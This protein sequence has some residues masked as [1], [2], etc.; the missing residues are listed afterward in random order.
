MQPALGSGEICNSCRA[1]SP[2]KHIRL[3]DWLDPP[4]G[5]TRVAYARYMNTI[6][7]CKR[8][9]GL[10]SVIATLALVGLPKLAV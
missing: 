1:A 2:T 9:A 10:G 3:A 7:S 4:G 6:R 8:A 5:G